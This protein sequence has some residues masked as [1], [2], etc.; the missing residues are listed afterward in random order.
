ML[1]PAR[2]WRIAARSDHSVVAPAA[3]FTLP[4]DLARQS[5][6]P[7]VGD[8]LAFASYDPDEQIGQLHWIGYISHI[9]GAQAHVEW[10]ACARRLQI[11]TGYGRSKWREGHFGFAPSKHAEYDLHALWHQHFP[12]L[13][14]RE[15]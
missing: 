12:Q 15:A 7:R 8:G 10:R 11:G 4:A 2:Y 1:T 3:H 6:P 14:M 13:T 5:N 9:D